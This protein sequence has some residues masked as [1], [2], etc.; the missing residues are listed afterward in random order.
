MSL[1]RI[2]ELLET[3]NDHIFHNA[4]SVAANGNIIK[5]SPS[6][7]LVI[8]I[9]GSVAN[10]AR[11]VTFYRKSRDGTL[12]PIQGVRTSDFEVASS[13]TGTGEE[14]EFSVTPGREY[15]MDLTSITGGTVTI[16]GTM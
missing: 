8:E 13:T 3:G 2:T 7:R 12:K 9:Y 5:A 16:V 4:A 15:V 11:T 14:W 1:Q 6:G 10:T